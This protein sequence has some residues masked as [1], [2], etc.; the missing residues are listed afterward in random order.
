M[1]LDQRYWILDLV[2]LATLAAALRFHG[3]GALSFTRQEA[4][5]ALA[6]ESRLP[7]GRFAVSPRETG[8]K[9]LLHRWMVA[10][11]FR[12]FGRSEW[13][14]RFP[15][16][17]CGVLGAGWVYL[18]G[19]HWFGSWSGRWAAF[20]F[21]VWP[22]SVGWGRAALSWGFTQFLYLLAVAAFWRWMENNSLGR[23]MME[24]PTVAG[25]RPRTVVLIGRGLPSF[26]FLAL[27][28]LAYPSPLPVL[29]FVPVYLLFRLFWAF[30]RGGTTDYEFVRSRTLASASVILFAAL[31]GTWAGFGLGSF[32][33]SGTGLD[34]TSSSRDFIGALDLAGGIAACGVGAGVFMAFG[35]GRPGRLVVSAALGPFLAAGLIPP[36]DLP[37]ALCLAFPFLALCAGLPIGWAMD[38]LEK[39]LRRLFLPA[40]APKLKTTLAG[41]VL[42]LAAVSV[43]RQ[44]LLADNGSAAVVR[45]NVQAM[46]G[47]VA[48]WRGMAD[49][50]AA[51]LD[52]SKIITTDPVLCAYYLGKADAVYPGFENAISPAVAP[53]QLPNASAVLEQLEVWK[54]VLILGARR[55]FENAARDP[56]RARLW[57]ILLA[58]NAEIWTGSNETAIRW[59]SGNP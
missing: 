51:Y 32:P 57:D 9:G 31:A 1:T 50:L 59:V 17:V 15:A 47:R 41:V 10:E 26:F 24:P 44:V 23:P 40:R 56:D 39:A 22:W 16:A 36:E 43:V 3:L 6:A 45:G 33:E 54:E 27:L 11:S 12:R 25:R 55:D 35:R 34:S 13:W 18:W 38:R 8:S 7:E 14:A 46:G 21:A 30:R 28:L 19:S 20:L 52:S 5:T 37:L 4:E 48:D 49:W 2:L 29:A 42:A 53:P 58:G